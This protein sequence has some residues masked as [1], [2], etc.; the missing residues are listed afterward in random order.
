MREEDPQ[1]ITGIAASSYSSQNLIAHAC[2]RILAESVVSELG[3]RIVAPKVYGLD[4]SNAVVYGNYYLT[5][6]EYRHIPQIYPLIF[7]T[8]DGGQTWLQ[9]LDPVTIRSSDL[10]ELRFVDEEHGW[11]LWAH[12]IE[13]PA[14]GMLYTSFRGY[15]WNESTFHGISGLSSMRAWSFPSLWKG[16][17][18]VDAQAP[19]PFDGDMSREIDFW[20]MST[21]DGGR[22]WYVTQTIANDDPSRKIASALPECEWMEKSPRWSV[23]E[24]SG[25]FGIRRLN[26]DDEWEIVLLLPRVAYRT[27]FEVE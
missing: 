16:E 11:I 9:A 4:E 25:S 26:E 22:N 7:R 2:A 20:K 18:V 23:E 19:I 5:E 6:P 15:T 13:G 17:C 8:N 10:V 14:F 3:I 27:A 21:D 1:P 12:D 24:K